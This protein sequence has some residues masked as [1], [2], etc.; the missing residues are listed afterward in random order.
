MTQY[1]NEININDLFFVD[2]L[3]HT[4]SSKQ[5]EN[6]SESDEEYKLVVAIYQGSYIFVILKKNMQ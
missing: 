4:I 6:N 1:S 5:T 2:I 3:D